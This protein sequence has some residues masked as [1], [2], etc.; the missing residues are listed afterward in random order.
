M[1]QEVWML[2]NSVVGGNKITLKV[3]LGNISSTFIYSNYKI[4]SKCNNCDACGFVK[5]EFV[6]MKN[7]LNF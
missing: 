3:R 1:L 7:V 4:E 5:T 6:C 2:P